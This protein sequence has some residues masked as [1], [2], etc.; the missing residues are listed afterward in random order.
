MENSEFV[1]LFQVTCHDHIA[2]TNRMEWQI[3]EYI[4]VKYKEFT[5]SINSS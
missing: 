2:H 1:E 3:I 4:I 5:P